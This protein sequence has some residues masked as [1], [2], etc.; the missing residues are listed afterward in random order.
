MAH[1]SQTT[2]S[3]G[4]PWSFGATCATWSLAAEAGADAIRAPARI[5]NS[6]D[7]NRPS[8]RQSGDMTETVN[9]E[10]DTLAVCVDCLM[11][12]ANGDD[13]GVADDEHAD[14]SA[15]FDRF[16][17]VNPTVVVTPDPDDDGYFTWNHCE[18]CQRPT[19]GDRFDCV[20]WHHPSR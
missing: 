10:P 8:R 17:S 16:F 15:R 2:Y 7:G 12:I 20:T 4:A 6:D 9:P 1:G 5:L 11:M 14:W 13:S 18:L 19:G 3:T